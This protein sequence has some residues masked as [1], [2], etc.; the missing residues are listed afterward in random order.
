VDEC[1]DPASGL[2]CRVVV[3]VGVGS[4]ATIGGVAPPPVG[5]RAHGWR[6]V[7]MRGIVGA[8]RGPS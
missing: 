2:A 6:G 1:V 5:T 7:R 4:R 3:G 8:R